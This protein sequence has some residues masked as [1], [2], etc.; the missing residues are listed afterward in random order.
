VPT[1]LP[2]AQ[3]LEGLRTA[4]VAFVRYAD[5]AGLE[6][7]V[8]T[9]PG[10]VVRDLVAHQG[11]AHRTAAALVRHEQ[12][13]PVDPVEGDP[14]EWLRDG[15]IELV[16]AVTRSADRSPWAR[17]ACHQTTI[18]AVDA[19]GAAL[20]RAPHPSETW[21]DAAIAADGIDEALART[22]TRPG[23]RL[24]A[25]ADAVLVVAPEDVADWWLVRVGPRPA[26]V[27]RG[28]GAR[29][30]LPVADWE[31]R[32]PATQTYLALW[33]RCPRPMSRGR[34]PGPPLWSA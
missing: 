20:G 24:H 31:V 19:L 4:M 28:T 29:P 34:R 10:W 7:P 3:H 12:P 17:H 6:A 33:D 1:Q 14:V 26:V 8:P 2:L 11:S 13:G 25:D 21:I 27:D 23:S 5:R 32:G 30:D 15:A 16:E 9:C 22:A 18:H